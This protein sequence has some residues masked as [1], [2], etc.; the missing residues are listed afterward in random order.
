VTRPPNPASGADA[1]RRTAIG[2]CPLDCPDACSWQLEIERDRIV[3]L[4]G[5]RDQPYTNGALC[6]KVNRYLDAVYSPG[7]LTKPMIRVGRK[8]EGRFAPVTWDD[9]LGRVADGLARVRDRWGAE[10]IL[11][12]FFAG[13]TGLVQG[14][15]MPL[16]V[17]Y[18]LGASR[19]DTTICTAAYRAAVRATLGADLAIDPEDLAHSRLIVLWGANPLSTGIHVW[20]YMLAARDAGATLVCI[21]PLRSPTA[22][23]CDQHIAPNPGTDAALALTLMRVVRDERAVDDDWVSRHTVG[24]DQLAK[25]LDEWPVERAAAICGLPAETIVQLGRRIASTRPTA[26]FVGLGLQRHG[27]GAAAVR[28]ITAI[29][30]LTGDW[31]HVGGGLAGLTD[32]WFPVQSTIRAARNAGLTLPPARTVNMSRLAEALTDLSD[33]PVMALVVFYANPAATAPD[34]RRVRAGLARDDLF[35]VVVEQRQTDTADYADVLLPATMQPEHLDLHDS[36]GHLYLSWNEP[37]VAPP[38]ECLANAEIFRRL[39]ARMRLDHP[40]LRASD[41]QVARD[42]IDTPAARDNAIT[43][44]RLRE[45]GFLRVG[46]PRG[47][48]PLADGGFPTPSGRV[49]LYSETLAAQGH[50]PLPTYVAPHEAQ[51]AELAQRFPLVLLAPAARFF[52]NSTF[53]ASDWHQTKMGPPTLVLHPTDAAARGLAAGDDARAYN[54]RGAFVARVVIS[55]A[56]RPGVCF[57]LK[58]P[59]AKLSS[60]GANVNAVTPV[61]DT[62]L[63]GGP[64]FHDNR[65]EV[66]IA[67]LGGEREP[68]TA[69]ETVL[70]SG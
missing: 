10:A 69:A 6:G 60:G 53:A 44:E 61:R 4:R 17:L 11:P 48:A 30:A 55:D 45:A 59:W 36:Y 9:A 28:A 49:E 68:R 32:G 39:A 56:T 46:P 2:V 54:D 21:D 58:T 70:G 26:L 66:V 33:P 12:Y 64:S 16:R 7:R 63:G 57:T 20:K 13:T 40:A 3:S 8:G 22:E 18:A 29:A 31:R 65:V 50:D 1:T 23:R 34:Q 62:D 5:R 41:E 19:L 35:C 47:V 52:L 51:N 25:R 42:A 37:A 14:Y 38:G 15:G 24:F 67:A 43:V 27:G